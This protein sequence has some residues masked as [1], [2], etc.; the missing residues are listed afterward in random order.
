MTI[1]IFPSPSVP[2]HKKYDDDENAFYVKVDIPRSSFVK[3][4]TKDLESLVLLVISKVDTIFDTG[5]TSSGHRT[6][7]KLSSEK[8][9]SKIVSVF[10]KNAKNLFLPG[11]PLNLTFRH[12][13]LDSGK[14]VCTHW[15]IHKNTWSTEGCVT[16]ETNET[17]THCSCQYLSTYAV[18]QKQS[19]SS[20]MDN[21][22]VWIIILSLSTLTVIITIL[23]IMAI[24]Y[25][26]RV[27]VYFTNTNT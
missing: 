15:D 24:C 11:P 14:R 3:R 26:K 6:L 8:I 9:V 17:H 19:G 1:Q 18:L 16:Q 7:P 27:K 22:T 13:I 20:I 10:S 2:R 21:T 5:F 4:L 23:V 12:I 25:C